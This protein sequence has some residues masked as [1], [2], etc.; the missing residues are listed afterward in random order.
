AAIAPPQPTQTPP[1]PDGKTT[2]WTASPEDLEPAPWLPKD[3]PAAGSKSATAQPK[4]T[5]PTVTA[6][7]P[8]PAPAQKVTAIVVSPQLPTSP[9]TKP[10][11]HA[12]AELFTAGEQAFQTGQMD[13]AAQAYAQAAAKGH[14]PAQTRLGELH[15]SGQG[16]SKDI[17]QAMHW[18]RRAAAKGEAEAYYRMGYM[19]E[20]G[21]TVPAD[22]KKAKEWYER[23]AAKKSARAVER[24][25]SLPGR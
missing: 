13:R 21:L 19:Y 24:L 6:P 9:D 4:A 22:L 23:A 18:F 5:N 15:L 16:V 8:A 7:V 12:P 10:L 17:T 25:K 20:Q 1:A 11:P 3:L 2:S 14:A